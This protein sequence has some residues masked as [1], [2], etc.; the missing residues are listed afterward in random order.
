MMINVCPVKLRVF[1]NVI[2]KTVFPAETKWRINVVI[3]IAVNIVA[4]GAADSF[5]R[6]DFKSARC[7][8]KFQTC[9]RV[10]RDSQTPSFRRTSV[11]KLR[12]W[13]GFIH[14]CP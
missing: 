4:Q 7:S 6:P 2:N 1:V 5:P 10:H 11:I 12:R 9:I 13:P 8:Y 3:E 14:G